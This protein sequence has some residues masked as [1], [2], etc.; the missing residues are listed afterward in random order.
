M[1]DQLTVIVR[2]QRLVAVFKL[3]ISGSFI[4]GSFLSQIGR[5]NFWF[6]ACNPSIQLD[7]SELLSNSQLDGNSSQIMKIIQTRIENDCCSTPKNMV[8]QL[9]IAFFA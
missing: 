6:H 4:L 2:V 1:L 9:R 8:I 7:M 5:G 3:C